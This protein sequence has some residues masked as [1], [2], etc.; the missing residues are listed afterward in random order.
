MNLPTD[1]QPDLI[2]YV[3]KHVDPRNGELLYIGHGARGRAWIHGSR[4]SVLRSQ[5]HLT[6]L[7]SMTQDGLLASDWVQIVQSG[8]PKKDACRIEQDLIRSLRPTYNKPQGL[9]N[10]K[11]TPEVVRDFKDLRDSGLSY[12]KVAEVTGVSPMTVY[13]AMN[14]QTKNVN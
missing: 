9:Q 6:H 13:R 12:Q 10:L 1:Y 4:K 2:Y 3:Y 5:E 11:A 8:L 7:E 14:G